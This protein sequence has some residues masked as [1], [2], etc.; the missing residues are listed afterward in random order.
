MS[1]KKIRY[2][3]ISFTQVAHEGA[4]FVKKGRALNKKNEQRIWDSFHNCRAGLAYLKNYLLKIMFLQMSQTWVQSVN[5]FYTYEILIIIRPTQRSPNTFQKA[6]MERAINFI[7]HQ[8]FHS[9]AVDGKAVFVEVMISIKKRKC[10]Y[11]Y[12]C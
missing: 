4:F 2:F 10:I 3:G 1:R 6:R 7:I 8:L 9:I 5:K 12:R 11:F